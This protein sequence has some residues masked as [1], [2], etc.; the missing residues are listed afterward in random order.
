M[1]LHFNGKIARLCFG[2]KSRTGIYNNNYIERAYEKAS[3][4]TSKQ[5]SEETGDTMEDNTT[6]GSCAR[7]AALR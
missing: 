3:D 5:A 6:R 4:G 1:Q 2:W 7:C